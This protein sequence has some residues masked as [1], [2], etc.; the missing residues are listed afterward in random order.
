[1][2][3]KSIIGL[4]TDIME[5]QDSVKASKNCELIEDFFYYAGILSA[6]V[7]SEVKTIDIINGSLEADIDTAIELLVELNGMKEGEV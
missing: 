3:C 2:K 5:H 4:Y 7:D 1:M 6:L